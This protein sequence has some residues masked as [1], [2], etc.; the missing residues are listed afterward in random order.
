MGPTSRR[1][2]HGSAPSR[3]SRCR[4]SSAAAQIGS[5]LAGLPRRHLQGGGVR[6]DAIFIG[7]YVA[8][9]S[10]ACRLHAAF[11]ST[12]ALRRSGALR[13]P[14][15]PIASA[16]T[17]ALKLAFG[18]CRPGRRQ[19]RSGHDGRSGAPRS[20]SCYPRLVRADRPCSR[21]L[22]RSFAPWTEPP[23]DHR[24]FR[25]VGIQMTEEVLTQ[26]A[27]HRR[28]ASPLFTCADVVLS[29]HERPVTRTAVMRFW[30]SSSAARRC[31]SSSTFSTRT[32]STTSAPWPKS[33]RNSRRLVPQPRKGV[34][35]AAGARLMPETVAH[36]NG[37]LSP[38]HDADGD[39]AAA[40]A[41]DSA[42]GAG[43][44]APVAA[45]RPRR[46]TRSSAPR[47]A[48][49]TLPLERRVADLQ[50]AGCATAPSSASDER[51]HRLAASVARLRRKRLVL[52][53]RARY[54][55]FAPALAATARPHRM[56]PRAAAHLSVREARRRLAVMEQV[57]HRWAEHAVARRRPFCDPA[58]PRRVRRAHRAA[59]PRA[60]PRQ[61]AAR[62]RRGGPSPRST[63]MASC[64]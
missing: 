33:P 10:R 16:A 19:R 60:R 2:E 39:A 18:W 55:C 45:L 56:A 50:F 17:L 43:A 22:P 7:S 44:R 1:L 47:C 61:G 64:G 58:T 46:G 20:A 36:L 62:R 25:R 31:P 37:D 40:A 35:L 15:R 52:P 27:L 21:Q 8:S 57:A 3:T 38:M 9:R 12:R 34:R 59:A 13:R 11:D 24:R 26:P 42:E 30:P 63:R 53:R 5:H 4:C 6:A 28:H 49:A 51:R 54:G 14:S 48:T 23:S 41:E 29:G 32:S